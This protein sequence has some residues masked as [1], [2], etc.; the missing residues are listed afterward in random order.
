VPESDIY[1]A[2]VGKG[3]L[4]TRRTK[5]S[6]EELASAL[7][8]ALT[9]SVLS[10][11]LRTTIR[12]FIRREES[13]D[14]ARRE[15]RDL[16]IKSGDYIR[17]RGNL[18][19]EI[20]ACH[21]HYAKVLEV[22]DPDIAAIESEDD[23]YAVC[24][25]YVICL[26][27]GSEHVIY[28]P[29]VKLYYTAGGRATVLNWRAATFLAEAFHDDPPYSV[30][31]SYLEDHVFTR[32]ELD[33]LSLEDLG[34]LLTALL[35]VKGRMGLRDLERAD[36]HLEGVPKEHL[37]DNVL[38]IS[39]FDMRKNRSLTAGEIESKRKELFKFRRLIRGR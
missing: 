22:S 25:R 23:L 24:H 8:D 15:G 27:D 30:E 32:D 12:E 29:E 4:Q 10:T 38:A 9:E 33:T 37:I 14:Q 11:F 39:R 6:A 21:N 2:T 19:P 20:E 17:V 3:E 7:T 36:Q 28:D 34:N 16:P 31:Y 13:E 5:L 26:D 18:R 1:H 35:Y